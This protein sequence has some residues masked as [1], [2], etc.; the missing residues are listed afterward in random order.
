MLADKPVSI[1]KVKSQTTQGSTL[2]VN[3]GNVKQKDLWRIVTPRC[4]Q[5]PKL[6]LDGQW[7]FVI[8]KLFISTMTF[9]IFKYAFTFFSI[10]FCDG[11]ATPWRVNLYYFEIQVTNI[12]LRWKLVPN[13]LVYVFTIISRPY[14]K[15]IN[16]L[17]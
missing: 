5:V 11:I 2:V 16:F 4:N 1:N 3:K 10:N 9:N 12:S 6:D 14:F 8:M 7:V 17:T 15:K 13:K